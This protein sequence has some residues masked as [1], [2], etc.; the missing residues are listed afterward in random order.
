MKGRKVKLIVAIMAACVVGL[1]AL[2]VY[3]I[4]NLINVEE[5]R[6]ERN[7][8]TVLI[9][10]VAN[11]QKQEAKHLL[12]NK[13]TEKEENVIVFIQN[14]SLTNRTPKRSSSGPF[15]IK[16]FD[17]LGKNNNGF[18]VEHF[19]DSIRGKNQIK[20]VAKHKIISKE[21][22]QDSF[23]KSK[24]DTVF[25]KRNH[26]VRNI[27][28]ELELL[29]ERKKLEE[30]VSVKQIDEMLKSELVNYGIDADFYFAVNITENDSLVL[31]KEGAD[32]NEIRK[33]NLQA[34][35]FPDELFNATNLL[36]IYFPN[37]K[38]YL[39]GSV[40]GMLIVSFILITMIAYIFY[41]T[42]KMFLS[43]KK[44]TE[45]KNDL[46]NNI[47]H[48]FKTPISTISIAC[49]SLHEPGMVPDVE[50]IS[51]YSSVI[52]EEN[53]RL[54]TMVDNLLN[55]AIFE[56]SIENGNKGSN[57]LNKQS[58][59]LDDVFAEV[60]K[61]FVET[62]KQ[63][64][65]TIVIDNHSPNIVLYAD[66]FHLINIFGNLID[67]AIKYNEKSP[68]ISIS[69]IEENGFVIIKMSDN[70]IGISKENMQKIFDTFYRVPNGNIHNVRGYGIGLSYA[71]KIIEAH[72]GSISVK[73]ILGVGSTFELKIPLK[74]PNEKQNTCNRRR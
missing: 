54:K 20:I 37:K 28:S 55:T 11:I 69:V 21:A 64:N 19:E 51:K 53:E 72:N 59:L 68:V 52:K 9:N 17:S 26:L 27:V 30:R 34:V 15:H 73:S 33:S 23:W 22:S 49:E 50:S 42:L 36:K 2:Q 7:V 4:N 38:S 41:Y 62:V 47:T 61:N 56:N 58:V 48:E 29:S 71:K 44:I 16:R 74:N 63:R 67:N 18:Y 40:S 70:G 8:K 31:I 60:K 13:I 45:V 46:I 32:P 39:L 35:L 12:L 43:Q 25:F 14:D 3:W 1:I 24:T 66:E 65:G 57:P 5:E 10:T 6:F